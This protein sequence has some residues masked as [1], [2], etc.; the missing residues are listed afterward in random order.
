MHD[1]R[2]ALRLFR[3]SPA[4]TFLAILCL[5]LG[6]GVNASIFS[7]LNLALPHVYLPFSQAYNGGIV[8]VGAGP[9]GPGFLPSGLPYVWGQAAQ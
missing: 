7:L 4:F 2:L 6:I 5:A 8:F 3:K 1:I 9:P